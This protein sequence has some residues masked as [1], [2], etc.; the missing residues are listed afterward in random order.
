MG[1]MLVLTWLLLGPG[2]YVP[3]PDWATCLQ[4]K[5]NAKIELNPVHVYCT[6]LGQALPS[7]SIMMIDIIRSSK[8]RGPD[9]TGWGERLQDKLKHPWLG[10]QVK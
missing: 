2:V 6:Q 9:D 8:E 1:T 4:A 10:R 5:A 3:M 7:R